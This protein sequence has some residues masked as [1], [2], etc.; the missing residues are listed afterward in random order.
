MLKRNNRLQGKT[1][2]EK[3]HIA[4]NPLFTLKFGKNDKEVSRFAVIVSK[5]IDLRAV[6]RN[7]VRRQI[8]SCIEKMLEKIILG[9]DF[10]FI[11]KKE[12]V[13]KKT[14]DIYNAIESIIKKEKLFK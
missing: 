11:V 12:A 3:S 8:I 4:A 10:L 7:R 6:T 14:I 13:G 5:K 9:Y 2:L 1:R